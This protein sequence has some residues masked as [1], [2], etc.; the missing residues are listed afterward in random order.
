M[1][2]APGIRVEGSASINGA[3]LFTPL[4][5]KLGAGQWTCLLGGSG[6]GKST[7]LRLI[8]GLATGAEFNGTIAA[9]DGAELASRVAYMAQ[10]DLLL[11]WAS[12]SQNV[13][14]GARLRGET[15]DADHMLRI[16]DR[17]GL[18]EHAS[19]KP[20]ELSGG[21]R[22]RVA[23]ART[24]MEDKP[25]ILLDEPFSALDAQ[26]RAA[27]QDLAVELLQGKTVL[28]VTHDPA[29]AARLGHAIIVMT[30][31]GLTHCPHPST[32]IPRPID[33][34]ETLE[35]QASLLRQ[36]QTGAA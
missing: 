33:D 1:S 7:V 11:P 12:I 20:I 30:A 22:Q 19:K 24:L 15:L 35:C 29:E 4:T 9:T 28:I 3:P 36:L 18:T 5:L 21:Q 31:E 8:S 25:I 6:V 10:D 34:L 26:T 17:V 2:N 13:L 14:L 32:P 16:L 27:M 23:L